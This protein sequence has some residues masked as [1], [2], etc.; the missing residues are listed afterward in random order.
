M[1]VWDPVYYSNNSENIATVRIRKNFIKQKKA[2]EQRLELFCY[3][4]I[5]F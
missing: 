3:L 2:R 5:E 1:T 4:E